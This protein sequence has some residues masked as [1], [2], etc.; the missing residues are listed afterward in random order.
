MAA[1][2]A[3]GATDITLADGLHSVGLSKSGLGQDAGR[4]ASVTVSGGGNMGVMREEFAGVAALG[5]SVTRM[6]ATS[7]R[8]RKQ[9]LLSDDMHIGEMAMDDSMAAR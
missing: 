2:T 3:V 9:Q 1:C 8:C 7:V 6:L 5:A 4:R